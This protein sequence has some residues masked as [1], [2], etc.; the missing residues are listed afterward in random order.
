MRLLKVVP[1][2]AVSLVVLTGCVPPF[3]ACTTI[4]YSSAI[5]LVEPRPGLQLELCDG[6]GCTP[7]PVESPIEMG[8]TET[9]IS[10]GGFDL[11]GDSANGWSADLLGGPPV[12]GHRLTDGDGAV[13]AE[14]FV[15]ADWVRIDGT[16]QCGGNRLADIQLT[17]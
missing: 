4:G 11:T 8:S 6:E 2:L 14:G 17:N 12:L 9:P 5:E 13:V 10:T 16:D 3:F 15:E 7:G 1:L